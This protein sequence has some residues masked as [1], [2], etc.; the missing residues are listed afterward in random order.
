M[1]HMQRA[2]PF[3]AAVCMALAAPAGAQQ[4]DDHRSVSDTGAVD[5]PSEVAGEFGAQPAFSGAGHETPDDS[6][7]SIKTAPESTDEIWR[8]LSLPPARAPIGIESIIG[9][10]DRVKVHPT[11]VH[12]YRTIVLITFDNG[13]CSGAMISPN[14]V[15]TAGHCVHS[16]G[17]AGAWRKNVRVYPGRNGSLSP[18]GSCAA[19]ALYSVIGWT[20]R[21]LEQYDY[22]AVKLDCAVGNTTGWLGFWWQSASLIG[23]AAIVYGYPGDK[24][25]EQWRAN[26][27]IRANT[28][29]QI[30]YQSDTIRGHSGS[31]VYTTTSSVCTGHCATGVHAYGLH[32]GAPRATAAR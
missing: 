12:P 27:A 19:K 1:K 3:A 14:T 11:T 13:R 18:Y 23:T 22:G 32:G 28:A 16:G 21:M 25:L 17:S 29:E 5:K 31:P 7:A 6:Q 24:P 30:F 15:L 9:S 8:L 10:D 2:I 4:Q 26:D 20:Q